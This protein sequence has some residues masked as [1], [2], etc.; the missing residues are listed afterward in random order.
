MCLAKLSSLIILSLQHH[1]YGLSLTNPTFPAA[2]EIPPAF[3]GWEAELPLQ[4][5]SL[6]LVSSA[7][8]WTIWNLMTHHKDSTGFCSS[9]GLAGISDNGGR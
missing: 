7:C 5:V 3:P 9:L 1:H 2:D 8:L 4:S 6:F